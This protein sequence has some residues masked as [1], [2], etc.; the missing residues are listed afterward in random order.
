MRN[1]ARAGTKHVPNSVRTESLCDAIIGTWFTY[2]EIWL[3]PA[4]L[5]LSFI[6]VVR[7]TPQFQILHG[8]FSAFRIGNHVM[9]LEKA[10]FFASP[11]LSA[12][13]TASFVAP[14][15][16]APDCGRDV[17]RIA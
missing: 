8:R 15:H 17:T 9:K 12:K 1:K 11:G 4:T 6:D 5:L 3:A 7:A 13:R 14:P 2:P 16:F 10:R